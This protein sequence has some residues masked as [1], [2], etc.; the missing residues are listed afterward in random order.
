MI[1]LLGEINAFEAKRTSKKALIPDHKFSEIR[2][3]EDTG[4]E[5]TMEMSDEE[6][7]R[8]FQ[9]LDNQRNLQKREICRRCFQ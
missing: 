9:L 5:N 3:D 6:I 4:E 7:V 2:W 1:R 8:K